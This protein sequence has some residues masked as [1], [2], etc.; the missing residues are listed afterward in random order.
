M[1]AASSAWP[2]ELPAL[3]ARPAGGWDAESAGSLTTIAGRTRGVPAEMPAAWRCTPVISAAD[4]V[5]GIAAARR[6]GRAAASALA[7][8]TTRPPPSPATSSP[9]TRSRRSPAIASTWPCG[10]WCTALARAT[11]SG[12]VVAARSVVS[13]T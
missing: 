10:T 2:S 4:S 8:S 1:S 6:P 11:S 5:V 9:S 13:R 3:A 7:V 12:A